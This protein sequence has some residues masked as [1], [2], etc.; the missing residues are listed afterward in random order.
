[1]FS[2]SPTMLRSD[3][4]VSFACF[5]L[6]LC[7]LL[8]STVAEAAATAS[9]YSIVLA[10]APGE[11]L[12]WELRNSH[13][14]KGHTAYVEQTIIK[15]AP[16]ERLCMG[17]FS[18]RK[19]ADSLLS[20]V[21]KIYPGA[22]TKKASEKN[23]ARII[24]NPASTTKAIASKPKISSKA[25]QPVLPG[26]ASLN[27]KQLDSLMQ[28]AKTDFKGKK[29]N[30]S[31]RYLNALVAAGD[32]KY[33]QE[34]LELLGLARQRNGQKTHAVNTYEKY[35]RL[36]PD[37]DGANRVRQRLDGLLT[38]DSAPRKK[39]LMTKT[40]EN[41]AVTTSGSLTQFYQN[42]KASVD[43]TGTI[44]TLSQ[45]IT[46]LDLTTIHRTTNFDHRY[47]F[48]SDHIYDFIDSDDDSEFR[49]IDTYYELSYRQTGSSG[50]IGRQ[51]LQV[52]G[53]LKRYDGLSLGYQF[54]PDMR[55]NFIGGFPVDVDNKSSINDHKSFYG[56]TFETGT[57]LDHWSMN[58]FYFDQT[59]DGLTDKNSI[60]TEL[61]YRDRNKL[62]YSLVDYD[63][64]YDELNI[65]QINSSI[66]FDHGRTAYV[67]ALMR[68][69]PLLTTSNALIGRQEQSIEELKNVLNI[70]Q[71]YQLARDR[72][73]NSETLTIGGSQPLSEKFQI[74]ADITFAHE[75]DTVASGGVAATSDTGTDYF[76]ST[77]LVANNLIMKADTNIFGVRYYDTYLSD[78]TSFIVNSRF[79]V[80]RT[81]RINPRLQYDIR[82]LKDGRSQTKL[83]AIL[84][85][86]YRYQ[87]KA[88]FDFEIGYDEID[89]EADNQLLAS[90]NLFFTLGYRWD[91]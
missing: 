83:R 43:G 59:N 21:Q 19:Q 36:Y 1:M 25:K 41:G 38:A 28:R 88:R 80:T 17:F 75:D 9:G 49:F 67:N 31:I 55:L 45:L 87:N 5:L 52:G 57:F 27:E 91:F 14:F 64:F 46:Y 32:H 11:K 63:L 34:A 29:Y 30:S 72:T 79:P 56:F 39:T 62:L 15:G 68:K 60:G 73:A 23:I 86:D 20:E 13:L 6:L 26:S 66:F 7:L 8:T 71:I 82:D 69:S 50:R 51:R 74:I 53:I 12:N 90:N 18:Q 85:T 3:T 58:L 61:H 65:L 89:D 22:W 37:T 81:W 84:R 54:T 2:A 24:S 77:Q 42:N 33:S 48:T 4:I 70:E 44:E 16:W 10:S 40:E 47:Q 76:F 35:L 78:V